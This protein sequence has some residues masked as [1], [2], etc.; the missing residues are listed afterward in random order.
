MTCARPCALSGRRSVASLAGR[1][2]AVT[3]RVR[4]ACHT[5]SSVGRMGVCG[6]AHQLSK[7][8]FQL[9]LQCGKQLW[10][11]CLRPEL[12]DP[13]AEM[14]QHIFD[15]GTAVGELARERFSGGV[16]VAEDYLHADEALVTT[17]RLMAE[18]PAAIFEA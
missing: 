5:R 14:Q 18:L 4:P 15:T 9:G 3:F 17:A 2:D 10:L 7:S 11:K 6:V 13:I 12:A 16:L 8:R 1:S